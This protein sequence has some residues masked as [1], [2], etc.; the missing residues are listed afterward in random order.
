MLMRYAEKLYPNDRLGAFLLDGT[1]LAEARQ[2]AEIKI[3]DL[4][5]DVL[6]EPLYIHIGVRDCL[7]TLA[8][9]VP[10]ARALCT[11][12][13][14]AMIQSL[15]NDGNTVPC[16]KGCS[17]CCRYV[18]PVSIPEVLCLAKEIMSMP[19]ARRRFLDESCLLSAQC[20]LETTPQSFLNQCTNS[21]FGYITLKDVSNWYS[22][23]S[24]SCP[25]LLDN[26][27]TIYEERPLACREHVV[28]G[29]AAGCASTSA[30]HSQMVQMPV[31]ILTALAQLTS[32]LGYIPIKVIM[33]PLALAWCYDNPGYLGH[34]WPAPHLV[35][36]FID[37]LLRLQKQ[38][39]SDSN[40][41]LLEPAK[42]S[43]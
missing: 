27:C 10:L 1:A 32:E 16:Q 5:I 33:L 2:N 14:S 37:I 35:E 6:P 36:Q 28:I 4:Q 22:E 41:E 23:I 17:A 25:F 42:K 15:R 18:V 29:S 8:D 3:Y 9:I 20:I 43:Q 31:S 7:A 38:N 40:F 11:K 13:V 26:V 21:N 12:L 24:L 30:D 34:S 19:L 39:P